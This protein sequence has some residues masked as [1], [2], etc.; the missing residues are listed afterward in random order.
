MLWLRGIIEVI[1]PQILMPDNELFSE[2]LLREDSPLTLKSPASLHQIC[3][4]M[5]FRFADVG[6]PLHFVAGSISS[7]LIGIGFFFV[8]WASPSSD[9]VYPDS[10]NLLSN[11]HRYFMMLAWYGVW[12]LS[13]LKVYLYAKFTSIQLMHLS[14]VS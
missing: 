1:L 13:L 12:V 4:S 5:L 9:H 11:S 14:P 2:Y 7:L 10:S 3:C 6:S 8:L